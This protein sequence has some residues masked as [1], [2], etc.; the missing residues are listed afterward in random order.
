MQKLSDS[1]RCSRRQFAC[2]MGA[3]LLV[4]RFAAARQ[5]QPNAKLAGE[6]GVTTGSF[7]RHLAIEPAKGKLRLLDL[8]RIMRDELD[9]HVIDL[10]TATLPSLD[11]AYVDAFRD[12]AE[13]ANCIITNLKMNQRGLEMASLDDAV[14]DRALVEY[15]RAIDAA[16]R[17]GCR[18]VRP[19]PGPKRPDMA[20]LADSYRRLIDYAAPKGISLLVENFGWMMNDPNAVPSIVKAVG[21]GIAAAP[22]TG[23]WTDEA[24]F[25][26]LKKA[27]P[28]AVTCDFKARQ[29][30]PNGSHKE[31]DLKRCFQVGWDAGFRG[32][33][34]L[35][36]FN[37]SLD[38]LLAG[39]KRLRDLLREWTLGQQG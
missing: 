33:W 36:H 21:P 20:R 14:R 2:A 10:M 25:E 35:E 7:M 8:P 15:R 19:L 22:D 24:R 9:M 5:P 4:T 28:L 1:A 34:C 6:V 32:P 29:L 30:Q 12:R 3:S 11:A 23:N 39:M 38:G 26:G 37:Q 27:Y 16:A 13:K 18:W 17:L 31:Y